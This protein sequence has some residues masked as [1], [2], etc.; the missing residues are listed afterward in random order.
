[1]IA[2]AISAVACAQIEDPAAPQTPVGEN[3]IVFTANV[4]TRT[5]IAEDDKT[6]TW[7]AGDEVKFVW[8][9]G[10]TT[11][12]ASASGTS[13]TFAVELAEELSEVYAVYPATM[14]VAL[15]DGKVVLTFSNTLESGAF[16]DADICVAKTVKTEGAWNTTLNFKNAACLLKVGVSGNDITRIQ[17]AAVGEEVLAGDLTVAFDD[18]GDLS[19]E[20]P[21]SGKTTTKQ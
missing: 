1:M 10:E 6:V 16:K 2:L 13:T 5:A 8:A 18:N 14:P 3:A 19:F 15:V 7:V 12:K 4:P 9:G 11:A 20:Y 21:E 17:I